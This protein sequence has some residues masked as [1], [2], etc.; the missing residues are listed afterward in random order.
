V[1]PLHSPVS[2]F[3]V[4]CGQPCEQYTTTCDMSVWCPV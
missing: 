4:G 3:T 2:M 1:K